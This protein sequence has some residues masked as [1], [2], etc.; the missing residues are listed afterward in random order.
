MNIS[1]PRPWSTRGPL[2]NNDINFSAKRDINFNIGEPFSL[3]FRG[4]P[5]LNIN[6]F[7][8]NRYKLL[9]INVITLAKKGVDGP[10]HGV[11]CWSTYFRGG[12]GP[13]SGG[14]PRASLLE[15]YRGCDGGPHDIK[16][17]DHTWAVQ[18][19]NITDQ[20][21]SLGMGDGPVVGCR[22][23]GVDQNP[24]FEVIFNEKRD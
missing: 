11:L 1:G 10:N 20:A 16:T 5:K 19:T 7:N 24:K 23:L 13:W 18:W 3:S 21:H 6:T 14:G 4:P 12:P 2:P 17:V 15:L 9:P 8:A 22:F